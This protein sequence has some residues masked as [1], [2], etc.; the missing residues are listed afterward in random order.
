MFWG[1]KKKE[2]PPP[3]VQE[4][5]LNSSRELCWKARDEFFACLEKSGEK[6]SECMTEYEVL[7]SNC[8][9]SWV[10]YFEQKRKED[11]RNKKLYGI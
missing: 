10:T 11:R 6:K 1:E 4:K 3:E 5:V 8:L 9:K 7:G 2:E